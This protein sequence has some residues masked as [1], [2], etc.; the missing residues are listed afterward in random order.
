MADATKLPTT[1]E[2]KY[3]YWPSCELARPLTASTSDDTIYWSVA[4][5]DEDGT[6]LTGGFLTGVTNRTG[7]T[8]TIWVPVGEVAADGL[9]AT[10]VIRGVDISGPDYTTG[11]SSFVYEL[12]AGSPVVCVVSPNIQELLIKAMQ[13]SV[14]TGGAN[15]IIGED[16]AGTVTISRSTGAGTYLGWIR[17]NNTTSEGQFSNNGTDW[18]DFSDVASNDLV[19]AS[20]TDANPSYL[21]TKLAAGTGIDLTLLNGGGDEDVEIAVDVTDIIDTAAGL[22][23]TG[24][25]I[26]ANLGNGLEFN[27]GAIQAKAGSGI[28]V[29]AAGISASDLR[30]ETGVAYE[31]LLQGDAV[32][33]LPIEVRWY[34]QMEDANGIALGDANARR[35]Y[36]LKMTATEDGSI[37]NRILRL[38]KTASATQT[39]TVSIQADSG[40]EP[41]GTPLASA[42]LAA[43]SLTTSYATKTFTLSGTVSTVKGTDYWTVIEVNGTDA[44]N[45]VNVQVASAWDEYFATCERLTYDIDTATWGGSVTNAPFWCWGAEDFGDGIFKTDA[46]WTSK[47][48][49]FRGFAAA[50]YN[51]GDDVN[52]YN[53]ITDNAQ[54]VT[55]A[56]RS[57]YY[58][59]TTPG[60][61]TT[62]VQ[63]MSTSN[64]PT[65][66]INYKIGRGMIDQDGNIVLKMELGKK[67]M[68][69]RW[70]INSNQSYSINT[71]LKNASF[72]FWGATDSGSPIGLG[73]GFGG[74][75]A[76]Q[77]SYQTGEANVLTDRI[78][79]GGTHY[80]QVASITNTG[81][82]LN[83]T[84]AGV[85]IDS[86]FEIEEL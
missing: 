23:E 52:I 49:T 31:S 65:F 54:G 8:E 85:Y 81:F 16:A 77:L 3:F 68:R 20:A 43:S 2:S 63:T 37:T 83:T 55:L 44:A 6:I 17:Y 42:T 19:A 73:Y 50:A 14:A 64:A 84:V 26:Q 47:T 56:E 4:P 41:D 57:T 67:Q 75:D 25:Q 51:A 72:K 30:Y 58:L 60:Q 78:F 80:A 71:W 9:S 13:G 32:C 86:Y 46:D 74:T 12:Q 29:S 7:Y 36:A 27:A 35:K 34:D 10:N 69:C 18:T 53:Y 11:S 59:S 61:I 38:K 5:R 70:Y 45:Y 28:T 33:K 82:L 79:G 39:I 48:W 76:V 21:L 40:G 1:T 22:T 66:E 62:S 24:N 15:F